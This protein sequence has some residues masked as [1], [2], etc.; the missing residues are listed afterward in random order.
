MYEYAFDSLCDSIGDLCCIPKKLL[1]LRDLLWKK[2]LTNAKWIIK[3]LTSSKVFIKY[4][5]C[6]VKTDTSY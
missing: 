2:K 3:N 4:I 6:T 1:E 5:I